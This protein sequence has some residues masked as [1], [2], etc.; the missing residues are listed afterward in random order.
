V[1]L[2]TRYFTG[3]YKELFSEKEYKTGVKLS[4]KLKPW[5]YLVLC[6]DNSEP[7]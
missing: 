6:H 4:L 2:D 7:E 1:E 5:E 3:I